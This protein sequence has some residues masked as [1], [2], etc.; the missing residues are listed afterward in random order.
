M[1]KK[2]RTVPKANGDSSVNGSIAGVVLC[3]ARVPTFV[4]PS[5]WSGAHFIFDR[6]LVAI[7]DSDPSDAAAVFARSFV[8]A[9]DTRL[10]FCAIVETHDTM[11]HV[12]RL[13]AMQT[14]R[15][16]DP[17]DAMLS[18]AAMRVGSVAE[19]IVCRS[20]VPVIV[21]PASNATTLRSR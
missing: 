1:R 10:V 4:V 5:G 7:D 3:G 8:E 9:D 13:L 11:S 18:T 17:A 12:V 14:D 19:R 21:V 15:A 6:I 20:R 2:R 16:G